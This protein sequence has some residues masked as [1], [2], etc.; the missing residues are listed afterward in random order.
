[1]K[2]LISV[3]IALSITLFITAQ[4]P[5]YIAVMEKNIAIL[6]TAKSVEQL[7]SSANTFERISGREKTEWLPNYYAAYCYAMLTRNVKG[8]MIDTYC[9][10]ADTFINKADSIS[11]NN[12]EIYALKAQIASARIG[13]NPMMRGQ[14]YGTQSAAFRDKSKTLDPTNPRPWLLEGEGNFYT[15]A[16]F[17]GGKKKAK[18]SFEK[19]LSL[20]ET[21]KPANTIAPRWG[22]EEANYFLKKCDE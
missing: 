21:F 8:D 15:P 6:D 3:A 14:K 7:Q 2:K 11:P 5:K 22:K 18:P 9:D 16:A 1:M 10:K 19:A 12:S 17:G 20:Y 13:V 4:N